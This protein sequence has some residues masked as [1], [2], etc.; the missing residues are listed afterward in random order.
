MCQ[1]LGFVEV[2]KLNV[3]RQLVESCDSAVDSLAV[4]G[5]GRCVRCVYKTRTARLIQ[6][7]DESLSP[8]HSHQPLK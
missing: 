4:T 6:S 8:H 3:L 2:C 1:T 5:S 7:Q